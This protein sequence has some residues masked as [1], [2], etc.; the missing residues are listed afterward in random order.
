MRYHPIVFLFLVLFPI[1]L[2]SQ[3]KTALDSLQRALKTAKD[4]NRVNTLIELSDLVHLDD[5]A[6]GLRYAKEAIVLAKKLRF[7]NG[8]FYGNMAVALAFYGNGKFDSSLVYFEIAKATAAEQ[9]D[10][11]KLTSVNMN[12]GNIYGDIGQNKKCIQ[13]YLLAADYAEKINRPEKAAYIKVN[14]GTIYTALGQND[15]ALR[16]YTEAQKKLASLN[17]N[18][19]KLPIVCNNIGSTYLELGD[20]SKAEINFKEALRI[21]TLHDN[22]RGIASSSEH[23]GVVLYFYHHLRDSAIA[24]LQRAISIYETTGSKSGQ[25]EARMHLG[26]IYTKEKRYDEAISCLETG[27]KLAEELQDNYNLEIYYKL[28]SEIYEVKQDPALALAYHKKLLVVKDTIYNLSSSNIVSEMQTEL[29]NEKGR[30]EIEVLNAENDKQTMIIYSAIA[31]GALLLILAVVVFNRY[32]VKKRAGELLAVQKEEIQ[33]QKNIIEEKNK[34]ITDSI[35]YAQRIQDAI[36]P[37]KEKIREIFPHSFALFRPKDIVSGDFYWF[38]QA[39]GHKIFLVADC[40]GHGVPGAMLSVVG[41]NILNKAVNDSKIVMPDQLLQNLSENISKMLRQK[42]ND[43]NIQ[44]GMDIAVCSYNESEKTMYYSGSFNPLYIVRNGILTEAKPD[45]IFIGNYEA[46]QKFTL[47][48]IAVEPGDTFYVFS[49]GFA[50]QFGGPGGKKFKYKPLQQLLAGMQHET[51]EAQEK[52]LSVAFEEWKNS[53]E[54]VDDVCVIGV[55][56]G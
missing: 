33:L 34:D 35:R 18:H 6:E 54:Q 43:K 37:S 10:L 13:Y 22:R 55:R 12:I 36:L 31:L 24:D 48:K 15:S 52:K 20:T 39:S 28:L 38:E 26:E 56:I 17:P 1:T 4:T 2:L 5:P 32:L 40:T 41:H 8:Y 51:M 23:L 3:N 29:A 14:I 50:D 47:H 21:A 44:D 27:V 46:D 42:H 53:L 9:N 19:E 49:D 16:Y 11:S 45:K 7:S 25:A 30:R